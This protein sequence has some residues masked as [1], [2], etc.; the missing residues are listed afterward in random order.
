[1]KTLKAKKL[2][3]KT[4]DLHKRDSASKRGYNARWQKAPGHFLTLNPLCLDC[5][6]DGRVVAAKVVDHI[7]PH[8]GDDELFWNQDNWQ[9]LCKSHH[10][11]KTAK[12]DG[13]FGNRIKKTSQ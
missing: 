4:V 11:K 9:P 5:Q 2:F 3:T 10:S 6:Q 13:G 12:Q 1:M 8:K 7:I